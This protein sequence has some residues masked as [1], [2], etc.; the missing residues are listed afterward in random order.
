[1]L[2]G[3]CNAP[4]TFQRLMQN[5]L[6]ELNLT[7]ML[8]YLEDVIVH[9]HSP[10]D[11]LM[12]L[13]AVLT[14]LRRT[15]LSSNHPTAIS[16]KIPSRTSVTRYRR[17][18]CSPGN[19]NMRSIA[20]LAPPMTFTG[21]RRFL[22]T[23]G[24][25]R[26]F[27][28]NFAKIAKPLNDL[29]GCENS[30]LKAQPVTFTEPARQAFAS[31]KFKCM[32]APVLAFADFERPFLLETDA[33]NE[34]LGVVLSQ[35]QDDGK[36]HP[37]AYASR[38]LKGRVWNYHSSKLEFLALKWAVTDQFRKYLQYKPFTV[39]TENNLLTYIMSTPNLDAT[40]HHWVAMLAQYDMKI[41]YLRGTDNN[42]ADALS[43]VEACL[44]PATVEEI[45]ARACH[46]DLPRAKV[47][48]PSL[49]AKHEQTEYEV[50]VALNAVTVSLQAKEHNI[51]E[52]KWV[53]LQ[54][55]DSVLKHVI[56]W[57]Q[58]DKGT[59]DSS[60]E[61]YLSGKVPVAD[62]RL[63]GT[64]HNEFVLIRNL[65]YKR[66]VATNCNEDILLFVVPGCKRQAALDMCHR[67]TGHQGRDRTYSLLRERF[68]W[69]GMRTQMAL[70]LRGCVRCRV[71]EG[72][73]PKPPLVNISTATP[74]HGFGTH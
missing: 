32:S 60:L 58:R 13:Q 68:W 18:V 61:Q 35:K 1:M 6:G 9:S 21:I 43:R 56:S 19:D 65:L 16:L 39:K 46:N 70:M 17:T 51:G 11:H 55:K 10:E 49:V 69:P 37:V 15:A 52:V 59:D 26:W 66:S 57:L 29:L 5:C 25:F 45:L 20:E 31:L 7:F 73:D 23:T 54:E 40:G 62:A 63:Y 28:K 3:L 67:D 72:R 34:G 42:V 44:D 48:S 27:I 24:Y 53:E 71:F 33:S 74:T 36:F 2:Y 14:A 50:R 64:R 38:G 4:A 8:I 41:E 22:G 12:Q 47:D 30:K